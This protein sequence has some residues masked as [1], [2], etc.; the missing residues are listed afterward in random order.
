MKALLLHLP[1]EYE[2]TQE[3]TGDSL[4]L[5]Y[6]AAVLRRDGHDVEMLD[7][8]VS[9]LRPDD[10][11]REVVDREFDCLAITAN[12]YHQNVLIQT[13]RQIR[14]RKQDARIIVGGYLPTLSTKDL[15]TACPE[16]DIAVLGEGEVVASDLFGRL[17]RGEEWRSTNG[18]AYMSDGVLVA[19]PS[20]LPVE[21]LD[22]LPFPARD[23]IVQ[24]LR[25][26][27]V[28]L[29]RVLAS[30]GCYHR[31]S[32]CCI[33]PFHAVSGI[34]TPRLRSPEKVVDEIESTMALIGI[35]NFRFS[36]DD[37]IGPS[38]KTCEHALRLV[39]EL[40]QRKLPI[41][42]E[43]EC[44]AD[45]VNEDIMRPLKEA[46]LTEVFL[47]IESGSQSQLDR[48]NKHTTVEQNRRAIELL[49]NLGL[50]VRSGFMMFDPYVTIDELAD[51]LRFLTETGI[52]NEKDY[53]TTE[54]PVL[55]K[56]WSKLAL[57]P[58]VP[59]LQKA[60]ADGLLK[61]NGMTVEY[62]YKDRWVRVLVAALSAWLAVTR[63]IR[64]LRKPKAR[65]EKPSV[66]SN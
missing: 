31:C 13:V 66:H 16:I 48:F 23:G 55:H 3:Y 47:G 61:K 21:D 12:H 24:T 51:N 56:A 30:R 45:V 34:I 10:L 6:I 1:I 15:L 39:E 65:N 44:R 38:P 58:G 53:T 17:D 63:L 50:R 9:N 35:K 27:P 5:G 32:F 60:Q 20:P 49:N 8:L 4:G 43:I 59:L 41:T 19:N 46:G 11:I 42:F 18:I 22:S 57:Y 28:K 7:A 2:L 29:I 64:R 54:K 40:R 26:R 52:G 62:A 14:A 25:D 36:D 37:F 33:H